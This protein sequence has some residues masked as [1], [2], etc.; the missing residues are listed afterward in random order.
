[1]D[2]YLEILEQTPYTT[3]IHLTYQFSDAT[4]SKSDPD[5]ILR[6][7]HDACQAEVLDLKQRA[8]PL[9]RSF[10]FP[11]LDQKWKVN[12][13]LSKWLSYC[14]ALGHHFSLSDKADQP[15]N[16]LLEEA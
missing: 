11:A 6:L 14:A 13:F 7:Y 16:L 4:G 9:T 5:A 12:M 2:L 15:E 1:M 3:L 10:Q 8:L